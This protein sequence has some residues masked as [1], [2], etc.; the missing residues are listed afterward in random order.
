MKSRAA[1]ILIEN[2]KIALIERN[3]SGRHYY[4]FP[5]G[6]VKEE[7]TLAEA[8]AREAEEELGLQVEIGSLVAEIWYRG[9]PQYFFL[10]RPT[11]GQFG[12]GTGPEMMSAPGSKNGTYLPIWMEITELISQPIQPKILR[13]YIWKS[14]HEGWPEIPQIVIGRPPDEESHG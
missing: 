12:H 2:D 14:I 7:E 13:E 9:L 11:G 5:G 6:K 4:A 8:A 3:R 1:V 10:A